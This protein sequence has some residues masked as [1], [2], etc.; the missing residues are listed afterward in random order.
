MILSMDRDLSIVFRKQRKGPRA[1]QQEHKDGT[2]PNQQASCERCVPLATVRH[3][4]PARRGVPPD[5]SIIDGRRWPRGGQ[6]C[7]REKE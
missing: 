2:V 7:D 5:L 6:A 1:P 3:K 4:P